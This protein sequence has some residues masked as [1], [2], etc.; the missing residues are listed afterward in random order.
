MRQSGECYVLRVATAVVFDRSGG[1][2]GRE[3]LWSTGLMV[4][5][6]VAV[7]VLSLMDFEALWTRFH[8]IA[9]RNDLWQLDPTRDYLIMLFPEPFWFTATIRMATSVALQTVILAL[10]GFGLIFSQRFIGDR[11]S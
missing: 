9:F 4:A 11:S 3:M 7:G 5:L 1:S 6:V 2:I 8:Q 10:L